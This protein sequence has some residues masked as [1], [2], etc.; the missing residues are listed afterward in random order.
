MRSPLLLRLCLGLCVVGLCVADASPR[1]NL[2][3]KYDGI[4]QEMA[5]LHRI[6]A[7]LIHSII[8]AESAYDSR[9]VS[10][11]G[12]M[13]LMQLMPAT[14]K[15]YGVKDAFD[16]RQN[17][18]GGVRYLKDLIKLYDADTKLVLAAYNAGQEAVRKYGGVPPYLE[19]RN[20]I[21]RVQTSFKKST[22]TGRTRIYKYVD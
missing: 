12:A 11:K 14:A 10:H 20:Y 1:S 7:E 4:V 19:T 13:G 22:I 9:A 5:S 18:Q 2:K 6:P 8:R 15:A 3:A 17:I 21:K 16:P